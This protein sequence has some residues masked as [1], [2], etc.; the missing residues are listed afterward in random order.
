MAFVL[1]IYQKKIHKLFCCNDRARLN[2]TSLENE[3]CRRLDDLTIN[4]TQCNG[5]GC[6]IQKDA[7]VFEAIG[8]NKRTINFVLRVTTIK[9]NYDTIMT[10]LKAEHEYLG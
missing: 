6:T 1:S 9:E 7:I 5:D 4:P 3:F 2:T 10:K 8:K